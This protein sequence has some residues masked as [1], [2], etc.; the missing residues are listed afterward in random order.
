MDIHNEKVH[1]PVK[2]VKD[3]FLQINSRD[4]RSDSLIHE[5][6]EVRWTFLACRHT[7]HLNFIILITDQ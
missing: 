3:F 2:N 7:F 5:L 1:H 6:S 4:R